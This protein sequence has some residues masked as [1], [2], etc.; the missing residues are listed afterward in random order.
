[1]CFNF[2]KQGYGNAGANASGSEFDA[3]HYV[4]DAPSAF[5]NDGFL[6]DNGNYI[7]LFLFFTGLWYTLFI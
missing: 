2:R 6:A 4:A 3:S 1:M 7:C 5:T